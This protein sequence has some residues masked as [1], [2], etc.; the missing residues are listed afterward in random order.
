MEFVRASTGIYAGD[1]A[2][3]WYPV[4]D[5]EVWKQ[6]RNTDESLVTVLVVPRDS[7]SDTESGHAGN[8]SEPRRRP[9]TAQELSEKDAGT[10]YMKR[11][12]NGL[13][14]TRFPIRQ[15]RRTTPREDE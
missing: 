5:G 11:Y 14:I 15:T 6:C 7:E 1:L 12:F 2:L 13:K 10:K 4:K 3:V 8:S 9:P